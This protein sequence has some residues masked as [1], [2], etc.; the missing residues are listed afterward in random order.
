MQNENKKKMYIVRYCGGVYDDWYETNLFVT[1]KKRTAT[2]YVTKFNKMIKKWRKHYEQYVK[3]EYVE[4]YFDR[5]S[6]LQ[7]IN[8]CY[9]NEIELR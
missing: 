6:R 1:D 5:W 2:K 8:K 4:Q 7:D 9:Y 3:D